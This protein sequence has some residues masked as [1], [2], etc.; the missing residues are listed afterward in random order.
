MVQMQN[1]VFFQ[2]RLGPELKVGKEKSKIKNPHMVL[3]SNSSR[4][5]ISL[6]PIF[7]LSVLHSSGAQS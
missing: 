5:K 1:N 3:R 4:Y 6:N 2:T 7:K